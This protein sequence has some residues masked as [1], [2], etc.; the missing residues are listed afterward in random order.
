M[1]LLTISEVRDYTGVQSEEYS[2]SAISLMI[3][4]AQ[5]K[6]HKETGAWVDD[7][8]NT[9]K[10]IT[11]YLQGND[12]N[13]IRLT[14][15]PIVSVSSL[16][17]D[18]DGDNNYTSISASDYDL[19]SETGYIQLHEGADISY[20]PYVSTNKRNVKVTYTYGI[21]SNIDA[22]KGLALDIIAE[23]IHSDP[24]R[25]E[26]VKRDLKLLRQIQVDVL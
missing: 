13:I 2:D 18:T 5:E 19:F 17:V 23:M 6:I 21:N 16:E 12:D 25:A 4:L 14:N 3:S 20:F 22:Y 26:K 15:R 9:N 7:D 10:T 11:E 24:Q 1:A 8:S